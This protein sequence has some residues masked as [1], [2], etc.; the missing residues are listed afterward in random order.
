VIRVLSVSATFHKA[1]NT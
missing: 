1:E